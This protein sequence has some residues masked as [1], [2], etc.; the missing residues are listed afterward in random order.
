MVDGRGME[1]GDEPKNGENDAVGECRG[2]VDLRITPTYL[3]P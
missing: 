1:M 3:L 2:L